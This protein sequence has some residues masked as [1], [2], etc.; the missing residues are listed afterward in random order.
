VNE[1]TT[2]IFDIGGVLVNIDSNA[3][4]RPLGIEQNRIS[5]L[6][7]QAIERIAKEYEIGHVGNEEFFKMLDKIFK[8]KH[9]RKKLENA[10]NAIVIEENSSIIPIVNAIRASYQTA[11][12]SNTNPAHFQASCDTAAIL[13]KFSK[14]YL[15]FRIGTAKPNLKVYQYVIRDLSAE[16]SSF[17][18]IDDL[19]ENVA[20]A[21]KCGM[22][23]IVFKDVPSLY[24]ELRFRQIL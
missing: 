23:G 20:A 17:L 18:F 1:I 9:T 3:F 21:V 13:K 6:E 11:I 19:A 15:S 16:P 5:R 22:K 14:L 12:L 10:W 2:V 7:K 8:G 4:L 24:S